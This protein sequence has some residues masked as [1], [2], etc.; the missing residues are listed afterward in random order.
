[1]GQA[2]TCINILNIQESTIDDEDLLMSPLSMRNTA[3]NSGIGTLSLMQ[4]ENDDVNHSDTSSNSTIETFQLYIINPDDINSQTNSI[5]PPSS[6]PDQKTISS[7]EANELVGHEEDE[8]YSKNKADEQV[9]EHKPNL[10]R[11]D[12]KDKWNFN[13]IVDLEDDM[14]QELQFMHYNIVVGKF[15]QV[16]KTTNYTQTFPHILAYSTMYI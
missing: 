12:T 3:T 14:K 16:S 8:E 5:Q 9:L 1:M 7:Q 11:D 4:S 2:C 15:N 13:D 6:I 10:F